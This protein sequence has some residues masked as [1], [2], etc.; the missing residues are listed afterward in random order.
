[1]FVKKNDTVIV[2][3]GAD[4]KKKG[5]VLEVDADAG[6]LVVEGVNIRSK[7][8]KAK[9]AQA[10]GGIQKS[11]GTIDASNVQV[12]CPECNAAA[13]VG[14]KVNADGKKYRVCQKCGKSVDK[15]ASADKK[16]KKERKSKAKEETK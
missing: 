3:A 16:E 10:V 4:K 2:L 15:R 13:R 1:M 12:I 14:Y 9:N 11:E 6:R 5:K 7:H 8:V